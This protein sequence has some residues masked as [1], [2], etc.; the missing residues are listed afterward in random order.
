MC[1]F[2]PSTSLRHQP[3]AKCFGGG[4]W[5]AMRVSSLLACCIFCC[6]PDSEEVGASGGGLALCS[7]LLTL[8]IWG[9]VGGI[10]AALI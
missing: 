4:G 8:S 1:S 5:G 3:Q 9:G 6:C 2:P 10:A 7:K